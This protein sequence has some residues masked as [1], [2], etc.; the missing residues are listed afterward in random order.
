MAVILAVRQV[1]APSGFQAVAV[2]AG[3]HAHDKAT[4]SWKGCRL[5]SK[6]VVCTK[7]AETNWVAGLEDSDRHDAHGSPC[8]VL[9]FETLRAVVPGGPCCRLRPLHRGLSRVV[10]SGSK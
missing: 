3:S 9:L 5:I 4:E 6:M 1:S 8:A 7:P 10:L 2:S